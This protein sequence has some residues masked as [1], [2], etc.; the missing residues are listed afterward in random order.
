M[1][2]PQ[3]PTPAFDLIGTALAALMITLG[4]WIFGQLLG[5]PLLRLV[6]ALIGLTGGA[7]P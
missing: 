2:A 6:R 7:L 1:I 5:P 4:A 3:Q